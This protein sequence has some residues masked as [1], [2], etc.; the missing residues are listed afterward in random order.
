MPMPL[1]SEVGRVQKEAVGKC[2]WPVEKPEPG[3]QE[4]ERTGHRCLA[5]AK[6]DLLIL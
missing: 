2:K 1:L 4:M 5:V 3:G 6:R